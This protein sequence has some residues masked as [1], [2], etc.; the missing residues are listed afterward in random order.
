MVP[1]SARK[2]LQNRLLDFHK[3]LA[4]EVAVDSMV[5]CPNILLEF[6]SFHNNQIICNCHLIFTVKDVTEIVEIWRHQYA[7]AII[8]TMNDIFSDIDTS[9]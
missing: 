9:S 7:V 8:Q 3:E 2:L 5:T 4:N 1:S 6:N